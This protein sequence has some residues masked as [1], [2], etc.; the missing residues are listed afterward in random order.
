MSESL[1]LA[2]NAPLSGDAPTGSQEPAAAQAQILVIDDDP[3]NLRLL[4][5]TLSEAGYKVAVAPS[6]EVALRHL[7]RQTPDLILCDIV[8]P[9][10]TATKSA[11]GSGPSRPGRIFP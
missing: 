2:S 3:Q 8:M 5:H 1:I 10:W 6:A 11:A 4:S 7:E 9:G